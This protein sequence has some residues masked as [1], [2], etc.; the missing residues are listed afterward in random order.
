VNVSELEIL[1]GLVVSGRANVVGVLEDWV[2]AGASD[3]LR[4][5]IIS[6]YGGATLSRT[7]IVT[8]ALD[9][10]FEIITG[11]LQHLQ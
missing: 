11:R 8:A 3:S 1:E 6:A 2:A 4:N 9:E 7:P 5:Y 10:Q